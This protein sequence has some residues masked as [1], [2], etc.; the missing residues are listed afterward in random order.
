MWTFLEKSLPNFFA[1]DLACV[2]GKRLGIKYSLQ[3]LNLEKKLTT[4]FDYLEFYAILSLQSIHYEKTELMWSWRAVGKPC[5]EISIG[6]HK[7]SWIN[8]ISYPECYLTSKLGWGT[9]IKAYKRIIRRRAA[10]AKSYTMG[11]T[12]S[13]EFHGIIFNSYLM[14]LFT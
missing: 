6:K 9:M 10:I 1:D 2:I 13:R 14:P 7:I 3:Y 11:G 4:L 12:L 5:F 8:S